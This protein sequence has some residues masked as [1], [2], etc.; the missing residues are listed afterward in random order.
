MPPHEPHRARRITSAKASEK[1]NWTHEIDV[2]SAT[3]R[4]R[5]AR[6]HRRSEPPLPRAGRAE[7]HRRRIRP[8]DARTRGAGSRA[9]RTAHH[10]LANATRRC[11]TIECVRRVRHELPM[12]SLANAFTDDEVEDFARRIRDRIGARELGILGGTEIR[13]TR[14]QPALRRRRV[15]ARRDARRRRNGRGRHRESAHCKKYTTAPARQGLAARA[16]SARRG[17]H[18]ACG[19][20]EVQRNG[21]RI[22]GQDQVSSTLATRQPARCGSSI[23]A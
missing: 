2:R 8:V 10:R 14:D 16:R 5:P 13:R 12:L 1:V 15:R 22:G 6:A 18:A 9:S 19:I 21:A 23:H 17:V 3:T 7:H 11:D 4:R 20:R